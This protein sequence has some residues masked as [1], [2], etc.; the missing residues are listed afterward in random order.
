MSYP[1]ADSARRKLR[2]NLTFEEA[3]SR[4]RAWSHALSALEKDYQDTKNDESP[5]YEELRAEGMIPIFFVSITHFWE[6][7]VGERAEIC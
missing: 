5:Y 3:K 2:S 7:L 6:L 4:T 1:L